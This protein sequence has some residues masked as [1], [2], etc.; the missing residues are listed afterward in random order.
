MVKTGKFAALL[1]LALSAFFAAGVY[2]LFILR[3]EAGDVFPAYSSLRTDPLGAK[4]LYQALE[5]IPG[6]S[7]DRSYHDPAVL[8]AGEGT[9]ILYLGLGPSFFTGAPSSSIDA[10]ET[11]A[12]RGAR[13][14][15]SFMPVRREPSSK[16]ERISGREK[17]KGR[18]E[19]ENAEPENR[20]DTEEAESSKPRTSPAERW[21][22]SSGYIPSSAEDLPAQAFLKAMGDGL[23]QTIA[24]HTAFCFENPSTQWRILYS[25]REH[26]VVIERSFEK[27]S[28][29]LVADSY[30]F[31]N[32]AMREGRYPAL[33]TR[34]IGQSSSI[35]FDEFHLGV[36][37]SPG[38]MTLVRRY[39]LHGFIASLILIAGLFIWR[40]A[41][42]FVPER[43]KRDSKNSDAAAGKDQLSGLINLLRRNIEP[44]VILKVCFEEWQKSL[45]QNARGMQDKVELARNLTEAEQA[46]S[47]RTR[48]IVTDY[49]RISAILSERKDR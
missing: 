36:S 17:E 1:L 5:R 13:L 32:E 19:P 10:M 11:L 41:V 25:R 12:R 21:E 7:V 48:T 6:L 44:A 29:V 45:G 15:I 24:V 28:I 37:E 35:L 31:S 18:K 47:A 40:N 3:F 42:P 2:T 4:A 23:P 14:V 38:V 9:T 49:R 26:P 8:R 27:G 43:Q 39:R 16:T 22:V 46:L 33:L 34:L 30:L 20:N